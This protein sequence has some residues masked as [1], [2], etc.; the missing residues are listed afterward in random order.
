MRVLARTMQAV[1]EVV[2]GVKTSEAPGSELLLH[3]AP[4]SWLRGTVRDK[5]G[6]PIPGLELLHPGVSSYEARLKVDD[7]GRFAAGPAPAGAHEVTF[8][9]WGYVRHTFIHRAELGR[10]VEVDVHPQAGSFHFDPPEGVR[11]IDLSAEQPNTQ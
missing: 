2:E 9:P 3:L 8:R 7:R 5:E 11:V 10:D 6:K 1:S 4:A